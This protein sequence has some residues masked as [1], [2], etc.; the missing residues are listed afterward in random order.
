MTVVT[1]LEEAI[2]QAYGDAVCRKACN[3][4]KTA[5]LAKKMLRG[6]HMPALFAAAAEHPTVELNLADNQ[7][8]AAGM[9]ALAEQLASDT[10]VTSITLR[11]NDIG[12]ASD[13]DEG[14][15]TPDGPA[16][17]AAGLAKNIVLAVLNLAETG[18]ESRGATQLFAFLQLNRTLQHLDLEGNPL[19]HEGTRDLVDALK[20]NTTLRSLN[21][22][23]NKLGNE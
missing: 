10:C 17:L 18:I 16:A 21:L 15:P 23:E 11:G 13:E 19:G 22:R 20:V 9:P 5:E 8:E 7:L 3:G 12:G 14:I 4:R 1:G 2:L 6:S